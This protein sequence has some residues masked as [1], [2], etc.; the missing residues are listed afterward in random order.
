VISTPPRSFGRRL[1][2]FLASGFGAGWA[3]KA[4]GTFG[5]LVAVPVYFFLSAQ[6][7]VVYV[8]TVVAMFVLG[9]WV[10]DIAGHDIGDDAP[11]IVWDEIVGYLI[12]MFMVPSGWQWVLG[13]FVLF[14]LFDV[15]KPF[16]IGAIERRVHGGLGT[17]LD[18]ALAG[19]AVLG[20]LHLV[21]VLIQ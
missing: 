15:L 5:T 12:A 4:P 6:G 8:S 10:C 17:M 21:A 19:V 7:L 13:G 16:P 3:P 2:Y 9:V 18:D 1:A 20:I 11:S 14:R